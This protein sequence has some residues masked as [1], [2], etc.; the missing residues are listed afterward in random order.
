MEAGEGEGLDDVGCLA[1]GYEAGDVLAS[2]GGGLEAPTAPAAGHDEPVQPIHRAHDGRVVGAHVAEPG[3]LAQHFH[4]RQAGEHLEGVSGQLLHRQQGRTH[5]VGRVGVNPAA[6]Y[7]LA[8][9]GLVDVGVQVG[10]GDGLVEEGLERLSDH[11]LQRVGGDGKRDP[12]ESGH[13]TAPPGGGV[14][15]HLGSD[16][17]AAGFDASNAAVFAVYAGDFGEGVQFRSAPVCAATE[18]PDH[19]I[20]PYHAARR[21]VQR[22]DDG[23]RQTFPQA[24]GGHKLLDFGGA[25]HPAVHA[26]DAVE[27]GAHPQGVEGGVGM[28]KVEAAHLVE[29]QV[30]VQLLGQS[31]VQ[32][33]ALVEEGDA[34]DGEIVGADDGGGAGAGPAAEVAL[35]EDGDV[36]HAQLSEVVGGG[37]P[38]HAAAD[39][40]HAV[41]VFQR[42]HPPHSVLA[43]KLEHRCSQ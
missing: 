10:G 18:P 20:M 3:P 40:D 30:E 42:A 13:V 6:D 35:V 9:V 5:A 36:L 12:G 22:A 14:E 43:K 41:A 26:Q 24:H 32:L 19:G 1:G 4:L 39:D 21:M 38:M 2:G 28:T 11:R 25:D 29:E 8:P 16:E 31:F 17:A 33:D 23:V 34:L 15:Y 27:L 37:Q 7:H